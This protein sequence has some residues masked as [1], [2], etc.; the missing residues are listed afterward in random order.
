[1]NARIDE[2][3]IRIRLLITDVAQLAEEGAL[4]CKLCFQPEIAAYWFRVEAA[5]VPE[6]VAEFSEGRLTVKIPA[7]YAAQWPVNDEVG[8][9]AT[10]GSFLVTVEKDL[11]RL[12]PWR[13]KGNEAERYPNP[14]AREQAEAI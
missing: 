14:R 6:A 9:S 8:L 2:A 12:K 7:D 3:S 1:M 10:C 11:R 4:E 13:A 5:A